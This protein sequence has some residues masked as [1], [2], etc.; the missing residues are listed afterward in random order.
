MLAGTPARAGRSAVVVTAVIIA[1][2]VTGVSGTRPHSTRE[3]LP[4]AVDRALWRSGWVDH[5][6][7]RDHDTREKGP[8]VS[9]V[10]TS[11]AVP[12][13]A[14]S[15]TADS[16]A[17]RRL[18]LA[19]LLPLGTAGADRAA[20]RA[21][22]RDRRQLG[23]GGRGDRRKHRRTDDRRVVRTA[24]AV[25]PAS[26]R[27]GAGSARL[28]RRTRPGTL[29]LVV[30][31]AGY[32]SLFGW[33]GSDGVTLAALQ[34]GLDQATVARV[35]DL[36]LAHPATSLSLGVFV[37][38]HVVG[39]ALLG[40]ALWRARV[41]PS[42]AGLLLAVS[43]PLHLVSVL[44]GSRPPDVLAWG[45][46]AFAFAVASLALVRMSDDAYDL[47]PTTFGPTGP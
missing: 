19:A 45:S 12:P 22:L 1:R 10:T 18:G 37:L 13:R 26:R 2:R 25:H 40:L 29:A 32:L 6:A 5:D 44:I 3:D 27:A 20:R 46:T 16:R 24:G 23:H 43:Q 36:Y 30:A 39:T 33:A 7:A 4:I 17:F 9:T 28:P 38:G 21:A 34:G 42:W 41:L 8:T 11:T 15:R 31:G 35:L 47:P 14:V